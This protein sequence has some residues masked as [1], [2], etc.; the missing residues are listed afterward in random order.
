MANTETVNF[1]A[2]DGSEVCTLKLYAPGNWQDAIGLHA[3]EL[4]PAAQAL[5]AGEATVQLLEGVR[6]EYE[7]S[8]PGYQLALAQHYY[9]AQGVV[10]PSSLEK[11]MHCGVLNPGLFTGQLPLVVAI[12]GTIGA[13]V[14]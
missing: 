4:V 1:L 12:G 8:V 13:I 7:L 6:Y 14:R 3:I 11:R 10:L 9:A 2:A 5:D